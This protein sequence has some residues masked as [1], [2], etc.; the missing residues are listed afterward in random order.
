MTT[1]TAI[2]GK[3]FVVLGAD[4]Q[5][6]SGNLKL[7]FPYKKILVEG[8]NLIAGAGS[9]GNL[10]QLLK[11][12]LRNL[13][14]NKV[15]TD[16]LSLIP[17]MDELCSHLAD[18]NFSLPLEHKHF[19]PFSFVIAGLDDKFKPAVCCVGDDGSLIQIPNYYS[20][21]SGSDYALS[22]IGKFYTPEIT[23]AD[24]ISLTLNA[25]TESNK[26]DCFTNS[27]PNV[28]ILSIEKGGFAKVSEF[29]EDE[30]Q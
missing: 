16:N 22:I 28:L 11:I 20:I 1:I 4:S 5:V 30:T 23:K 13:R 26:N 3:N 6:T 2:R 14:I 27:K 18:L 21:G 9:V 12:A 7:P 29:E 19:N 24:A 10:Q 25:L 17:T 8:N 15:A